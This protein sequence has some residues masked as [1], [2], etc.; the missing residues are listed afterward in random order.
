MTGRGY[1]IGSGSRSVPLSLTH[2]HTNTH[3]MVVHSPAHPVAVSGVSQEHPLSA[4]L[5]LP[6]SVLV[7]VILPDLLARSW[8]QESP[9]LPS[10]SSSQLPPTPRIIQTSCCKVPCLLPPTILTL[11]SSTVL[12]L[13]QGK[14]GTQLW[15]FLAASQSLHGVSVVHKI[16]LSQSLAW[17]LLCNKSALCLDLM[18]QYGNTHSVGIELWQRVKC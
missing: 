10:T 4:R 13:S 9:R 3:P 15:A 11:A 18:L 14:K 12:S 8:R 1:L 17:F 16:N 7:I 6:A 5:W 2:I